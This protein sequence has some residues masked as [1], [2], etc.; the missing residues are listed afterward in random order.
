MIYLFL[1]GHDFKHTLYNLI[2]VFFPKQKIIHIESIRDYPG[3]NTLIV[4]SLKKKGNGLY[5]ETKLYMEGNVLKSYSED[6][7][8][9]D[10]YTNDREKIIKFGL[11][12]AL[13]STLN[14]ISKVKTSWGI[15]TGIRPI[16]IVHD[17]IN[18]EVEDS[19]IIKTLRDEYKLSLD[20]SQL[21]LNI[22]K[23][24][25]KHIYPIKGD[26]YSLYIS[27]PF[28]PTRCL[29]CS[30]P[31][32]SISKYKD[33]VEKYISKLIY[34]IKEINKMMKD[35]EINTVYIGGGTPTAIPQDKLERIIQVI[36][37]NFGA[38]NIKE[39]T[40]EAGRPDTINIEY[41]KM[42]KKN[43]INRISINPQTMN[44]K[45]LKIIGRNHNVDQV[46]KASY[47]AREI[48]FKTINMDLIIGLPGEG[49]KEIKNTLKQIKRLDPENLTIHTLAIKTKSRL[50]TTLDK[51][52]L[53]NQDALI[54]ILKETEKYASEMDLYPYYL[55]RQKKILGNLENIGYSKRNEEC[56]YNIVMMEE[57]ETIIGA[58]MG[59]VSKIY[60]LKEDKIKRV[61]NFKSLNEYFTRIDENINNK[62]KVLNKI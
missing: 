13:Y 16:K 34:E 38:S 36:Y 1:E 3:K 51:Y 61:P 42:L 26:K 6:I 2:R 41:L 17:L 62:Y 18:K 32:L 57:K 52:P 45:T 48:G 11:R 27:I 24:Q 15:L 7:N 35:K 40:V 37:E 59:A 39:F 50:K 54:N 33:H 14:D 44:D 56:I 28:C 21:I 58:G 53:E 25:R 9:I 46:L 31:S 22:G 60:F 5:G 29:Y 19:K 55:Y 8:K 10:I 4:V 30:F 23:S 49:L 20:K 43:K 47:L 12:K